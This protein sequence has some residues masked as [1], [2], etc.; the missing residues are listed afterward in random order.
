MD[1]AL[2]GEQIQIRK[3][4]A[5]VELCPALPPASASSQPSPRE[6]LR[7]LQASARM[8]PADAERYL[9]EVREERLAAE[10]RRAAARFAL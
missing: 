9:H 3:G 4:Q 7:R 1:L 10:D 5:I 2:A 6:M 8:T